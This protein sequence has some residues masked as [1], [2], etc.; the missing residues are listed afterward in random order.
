[1]NLQVVPV[2]GQGPG[3]H[4]GSQVRASDPDIDH[5]GKGLSRISLS[6]PADDRLAKDLHLLT[7]GFYFPHYIF[8]I[9]EDGIGGRCPEGRMQDGTVLGF[10]DPVPGKITRDRLLQAAFRRKS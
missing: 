8:S 3:D 7:Y 1:M 2:M 6:L 5:I 10:V 9:K 4:H